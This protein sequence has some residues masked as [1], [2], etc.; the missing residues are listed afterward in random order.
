MIPNSDG[1][2]IISSS[3]VTVSDCHIYAGDDAIVL[4]DMVGIMET[5]DLKIY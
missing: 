1:I 3:D 4:V 5:Q 2:D